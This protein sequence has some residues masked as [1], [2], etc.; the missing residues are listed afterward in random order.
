MPQKDE[1]DL[2]PSNPIKE[3][4]E[5]PWKQRVKVEEIWLQNKKNPV[6]TDSIKTG[7]ESC[8]KIISDIQNTTEAESC[9]ISIPSIP[10][11]SQNPSMHDDGSAEKVSQ[12]HVD[13]NQPTING[14]AEATMKEDLPVLTHAAVQTSSTKKDEKKHQDWDVLNVKNP[15]EITTLAQGVQI[16]AEPHITEHKSFKPED[17]AYAQFVRK[18]FVRPPPSLYLDE[19]VL[20]MRKRRSTDEPPVSKYAYNRYKKKKE[21]GNEQSKIVVPEANVRRRCDKCL[22]FFSSLEEFQK[23]QALNTCSSLFGFDSDDDS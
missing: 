9:T 19:S 15:E 1:L 3:S 11:Q 17:P 16:M 4:E 2:G 14:T 23:H 5:A 20:S 21:A 13:D 10:D 18:H 6:H 12:D 7:D 8:E 22:A